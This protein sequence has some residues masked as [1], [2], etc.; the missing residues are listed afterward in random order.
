MEIGRKIVVELSEKYNFSR[1]EAS[2]WLKLESLRV[3]ISEKKEKK[4]TLLVLPFCG[5][6]NVGSCYGIRLNHGLYTQCSNVIT[7][8]IGEYPVCST[9]SKQVEK[10]S[11]GEPTYGYITK[12]LE[13]GE[14]YKDPKG[15]S[16]VN[17][18]NIMDKLNITRESAIKAAEELGWTIPE[19]QFEVKRATRGRPKK[20][21]SAVDTSSEISEE[22]LPQ[23]EKK[24]GRPKK[25]KKV[26][27]SNTGDDIINDLVDRTNKEPASEESE[28]E[29]SEGE[30][31][32][33]AQ[34][35]KMTKSGYKI[36]DVEVEG[37]SPLGTDYLI[38]LKDNNLY[39][40]ITFDNIG[41]W[42]PKTKKI[43]L[44]ESDG[45]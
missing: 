16:P 15:K 23:V 24:R 12:R 40:P 36:L 34:P 7:S 25:D 10:N 42:N 33:S 39:D 9:C 32:V 26:V 17:Y 38:N 29:E 18:G 13:K 31:Q 2:E 1:E 45:E 3:D 19:S 22:D 44:A 27:S 8:R 6:I 37:E 35:I 21:A 14:D 28:G 41:S 5:K 20:D 30:E 43:D 11:N 4:G